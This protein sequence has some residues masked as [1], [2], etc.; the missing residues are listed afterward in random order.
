MPSECWRW[1]G[2]DW[3]IDRARKEQE[4]RGMGQPTGLKRR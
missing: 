1:S 2:E 4:T 3:R